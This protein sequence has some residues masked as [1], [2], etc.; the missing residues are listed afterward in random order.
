MRLTFIFKWCGQ[1]RLSF[2]SNGVDSQGDPSFQTG[3]TGEV[4]LPFERGG[5]VMLPFVSNGGMGEVTLLFE[6]DRRVGLPF[7]SNGADE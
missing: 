2:L 6:W 3:W 5:Q 1:V 4:T 7:L